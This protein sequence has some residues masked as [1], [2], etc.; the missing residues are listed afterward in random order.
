MY[1]LAK[2]LFDLISSMSVLLILWPLL[3]AIG[4]LISLESRGG[5]LFEQTRVGKNGKAFKLYK[6]R[7]MYINADSKGQITVGNDSRVTPLGKF[8]RKFKLD[9]LPQLFNVVFGE[10]SIVGPR[11]EVP[12]Y[13]SMYTDEQRKVLTV[14]PGLTDLASLACINEQEVLGQSDNPIK[15]YIEEIM[16]AKLKLNLEYIVKCG[17]FFDLALIFKTIGKL[18]VFHGFTCHSFNHKKKLGQEK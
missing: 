12:Q 9:E 16:P 6:F 7:S 3:I 17:F 4:L 2:R 15:L 13:V 14:K 10:M 8:L 1:R 18:L 11:P 5:P